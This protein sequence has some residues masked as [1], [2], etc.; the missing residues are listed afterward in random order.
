MQTQGAQLGEKAQVAQGQGQLQAETCEIITQESCCKFRQEGGRC[1]RSHQSPGEDLDRQAALTHPVIH[2][3]VSFA[4]HCTI[5]TATSSRI[6]TCVSENLPFYNH[7]D[8][9]IIYP[10]VFLNIMTKEVLKL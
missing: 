7:Q 10:F 9:K 6:L 3:R 8:F 1:I 2:L 4:S 5:I